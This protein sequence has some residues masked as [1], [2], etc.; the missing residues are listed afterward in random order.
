MAEI[1]NSKEAEGLV[2]QGADAYGKN[3]Y[4]KAVELWQKAADMENAQ[5]MYYL[6]TCCYSGKGVPKDEEKSVEWYKKAAKLG[7]EGAQDA[8][9][10]RGIKW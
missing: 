3:D 5:A 10:N 7:H 9:K 4:A 6:A 2:A 8:L 1:K